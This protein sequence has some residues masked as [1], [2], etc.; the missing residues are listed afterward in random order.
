MF[1]NLNNNI[2]KLLVKK[3]HR[4]W[5][6]ETHFLRNII[7]I[8]IYDFFPFCQLCLWI[9]SW[10]IGELF[11]TQMNAFQ[12]CYFE[13][14]AVVCLKVTIACLIELIVVL[15]K[16]FKIIIFSTVSTCS[17]GD[18]HSHY[19]EKRARGTSKRVPPHYRSPTRGQILI[20]LSIVLC[21]YYFYLGTAR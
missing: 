10:W 5:F 20:L 3:N 2:Y 11:S 8:N 15:K 9:P 17:S 13:R 19:Q 21:V 16:M 1:Q 4:N 7:K 14:W 18:K 12:N 6:N